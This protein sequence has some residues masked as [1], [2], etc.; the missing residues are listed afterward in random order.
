MFGSI[1]IPVFQ[2]VN[3]HD[4]YKCDNFCSWADT[5]TRMQM[6]CA[7]DSSDVKHALRTAVNRTRS[8]FFGTPAHYWTSTTLADLLTLRVVAKPFSTMRAAL[9]WWS[10][11]EFEDGVSHGGQSWLRRW[12]VDSFFPASPF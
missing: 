9:R 10:G 8:V 3:R 7:K 4:K 1:V 2:Q 11:E 6:W 5:I 12:A